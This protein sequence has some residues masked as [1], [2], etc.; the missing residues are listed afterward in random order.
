[1]SI[2]PLKYEGDFGLGIL[3]VETM[4]DRTDIMLARDIQ[5]GIKR[6]NYY[7]DLSQEVPAQEYANSQE[8]GIPVSQIVKNLAHQGGGRSLYYNHQIFWDMDLEEA[9]EEAC[10]SAIIPDGWDTP[11]T[12]SEQILVDG[13]SK[14]HEYE[15]IVQLA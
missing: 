12:D 8:S 13:H 4:E 15:I 6:D 9:R 3:G 5:E 11:I 14:G 7:R 2:S 1:M 10:I